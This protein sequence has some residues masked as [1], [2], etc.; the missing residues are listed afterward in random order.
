[1]RPN[2]KCIVR[3]CSGN[4]EY[5]QPTVEQPGLGEGCAVVRLAKMYQPSGIRAAESASRGNA[6]DESVLSKLL[7]SPD[8]RAREGDQVTIMGIAMRVVSKEPRL[9]AHGGLDHF[10]VTLELWA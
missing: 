8:T 4:D 6:R 3:R 5:G 9:R 2:A 7:L 1:M 10:E